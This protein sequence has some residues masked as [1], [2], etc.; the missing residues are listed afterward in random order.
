MWSLLLS[1]L[2]LMSS[3]ILLSLLS[4][5]I[6]TS[7]SRKLIFVV[8]WLSTVIFI[9]QWAII[10]SYIFTIGRFTDSGREAIAFPFNMQLPTTTE[11]GCVDC[12]SYWMWWK[13]KDMMSL[14]DFKG[15]FNWSKSRLLIWLFGCCNLNSLEEGSVIGAAIAVRWG[16]LSWEI[17]E[18]N[19]LLY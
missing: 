15:V 8:S 3:F 6:I 17:I 5:L 9:R 13:C 14:D 11:E 16:V 7:F 12:G 10:W 18:S 2:F 19:V 4:F 1:L